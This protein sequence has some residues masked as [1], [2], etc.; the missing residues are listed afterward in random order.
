MRPFVILLRE[1]LEAAE[2]EQGGAQL[3]LDESFQRAAEE[4]LRLAQELRDT[5][6]PVAEALALG[7][8][9]LW[10]LAQG[11]Q[12]EACRL[13]QQAVELHPEL[14][15][16]L[17]LR[18]AAQLCVEERA[19]LEEQIRR[20]KAAWAEA[21]VPCAFSGP[22]LSCPQKSGKAFSNQGLWAVPGKAR[23]PERK[24]N[25]RRGGLLPGSRCSALG[26]TLRGQAG[27][28]LPDSFCATR[29]GEGVKKVSPVSL[30]QQCFF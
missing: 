28:G 12:G 5:G 15:N 2:R 22:W 20:L 30:E 29:G 11:N 18:L 1:A 21:P 24:G 26:S 3:S 23:G 4:H 27:L 10:A 17:A 13:L 16:G 19:L 7:R 8:Q 9:A 25:L 14:G 6:D